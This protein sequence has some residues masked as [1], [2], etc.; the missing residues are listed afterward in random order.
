[1][2]YTWDCVEN[3]VEDQLNQH[4]VSILEEKGVYHVPDV[5]LL[6]NVVTVHLVLSVEEV[7]QLSLGQ[8]DEVVLLR[9]SHVDFFVSHQHQL[10]KSVFNLECS[11]VYKKHLN[12]IG[13]R[14]LFALVEPHGVVKGSTVDV[15]LSNA[16]VKFLLEEGLHRVQV[17]F[18]DSALGDILV[19]PRWHSNLVSKCQPLVDVSILMRVKEPTIGLARLAQFPHFGEDAYQQLILED[20]VI[21]LHFIV[22]QELNQMAE[23]IWPV[24]VQTVNNGVAEQQVG[25]DVLLCIGNQDRVIIQIVNELL[26]DFSFFS[27]VELIKQGVLGSLMGVFVQVLKQIV[28]IHQE[29]NVGVTTQKFLRLQNV[30]ICFELVVVSREVLEASFVIGELKAL[31]RNHVP[32]DPVSILKYEFPLAVRQK[33]L[34]LGRHLGLYQKP[35][36][37]VGLTGL[38]ILE[39]VG[40][41]RFI[42]ELEPL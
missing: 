12:W 38:I 24:I 40:K 23:G 22:H 30:G 17:L 36:H 41:H 33:F 11:Q 3:N 10:V 9:V 14:L 37:L 2:H 7:G 29:L 26:L 8:S 16:L 34:G 32:D 42:R 15:H 20:M 19:G 18:I 13:L 35:R 25:L 21:F 5:S 6:L 27:L 1:M 39:E 4:D 28:I 31:L